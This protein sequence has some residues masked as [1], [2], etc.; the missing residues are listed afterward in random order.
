MV[1]IP[2]YWV[3]SFTSEPFGGGAT[4]VYILEEELADSILSNIAKETG[5]FESAFVLKTGENIYDLRWFGGSGFEV[6][7]AGYAT[8]ATTH[9]LV[10]ELGVK[11]PIRYN[12]KSGRWIGETDGEKYTV[13]LPIIGDFRPVEYPE[14]SEILGVEDCIETLYNDDY[15]V[16]CVVL[17]NQKQIS[18]LNP[19][20][21]KIS[22]F[23][24]SMNGRSIIATS[25]GDHGF[26]FAYRRFIRGREDFD[27]GT[28]QAGLA[29]Y[30]SGKL[31]KSKLSSIQPHSRVS[32]IE[33]EPL[34]NGVKITS[35]ARILIKG[36]MYL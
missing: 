21:C 19:D 33:S 32:I 17:K 18:D 12:T 13:F 14:I 30:W 15:R 31:G 34:E 7:G 8:L 9:V 24:N 28:A 2:F 10:T 20:L 16:Y 22:E 11:T 27:C 6:P 26:D 3:D 29:P 4:T 1:E 25:R 5:V 36:T 23:L 35:K